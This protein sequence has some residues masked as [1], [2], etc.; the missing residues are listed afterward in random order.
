MRKRAILALPP[1]LLFSVL[2]IKEAVLLDA[3]V[4]HFMTGNLEIAIES[5]DM[6]ECPDFGYAQTMSLEEMKNAI[7]NRQAT[8]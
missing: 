1:H 5:P 2:G 8:G 7:H 4:D 6:P 3:Q